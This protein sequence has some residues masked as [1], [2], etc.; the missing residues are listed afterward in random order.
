MKEL[1]VLLGVYF[2]TQIWP[3]LLSISTILDSN[4]MGHPYHACP[5]SLLMPQKEMLAVSG[6]AWQL[7]SG[8]GLCLEGGVSNLGLVPATLLVPATKEKLWQ[9]QAYPVISVFNAECDR[10]PSLSVAG[11]E[12]LAISGLP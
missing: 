8:L 10:S 11:E 5:F 4:E 7:R 2:Y 6:L 9:S 12:A 1:T 3:S